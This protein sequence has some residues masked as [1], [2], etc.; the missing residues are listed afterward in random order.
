MSPTTGRPNESI[1]DNGFEN[2]CPECDKGF[3]Q[4]PQIS[5]GLSP[6]WVR[7]YGIPT[8]QSIEQFN[9]VAVDNEGNIYVGGQSEEPFPRYSIGIL[10]KYN[11]SG[12]QQWLI[13]EKN[14]GSIDRLAVDATGNLYAGAGDVMLKFDSQGV[15]HFSIDT[16]GSL[17][18]IDAFG[19]IF[20]ARSHDLG[21]AGSAREI[22]TR[23][24]NSDGIHQWTAHYC[25]KTGSV[26]DP[27][28]IVA[29]GSGGIVVTGGGDL[30][31]TV[32]GIITVKYA[33]DGSEQWRAKYNSGTG[34]QVTIDKSGT[35]YLSV[36]M[37]DGRRSTIK[38]DSSGTFQWAAETSGNNRGIAVDQNGNVIV[39][40]EDAGAWRT[41]KYG[42]NGIQKWN[43]TYDKPDYTIDPRSMFIDDQDNIYVAGVATLDSTGLCGIVVLCYD[44]AGIN[45]WI[46]DSQ[47]GS[48][49]TFSNSLAVDANGNMYIAGGTCIWAEFCW[50]GGP[51]WN[52]WVSDKALLWKLG[53]DKTQQWSM[54]YDAPGIYKSAVLGMSLDSQGN[55][56]V[57]ETGI[58]ADWWNSFNGGRLSIL[59]YDPLGNLL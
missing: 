11:S 29:D 10:A 43:Q 55:V 6:T 39:V 30:T 3:N 15:K 34:G 51:Q 1:S 18:T 54:E 40:M 23:K 52:T 7:E 32:P 45:K 36:T 57:C 21:Q 47:D 22:V 9:A 27:T 24:Y 38:Y 25:Y 48:S 5:A 44:P 28:D 8:D 20:S 53:P 17:I 33:S 19:N 2:N 16:C 56:Y 35:V 12:E 26:N 41:V 37:S 4:D 50:S 13:R 31:G 58:R 49:Y 46:F 14:V 59:K 42:Q